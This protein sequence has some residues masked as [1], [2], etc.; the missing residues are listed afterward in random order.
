VVRTPPFP[1]SFPLRGLG[2][3][4]IFRNEIAGLCTI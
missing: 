1:L 2:F 4:G 3:T